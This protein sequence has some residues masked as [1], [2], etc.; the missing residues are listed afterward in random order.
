MKYL[1]VIFICLT[2]ISCNQEKNQNTLSIDVSKEIIIPKHYIVAKTNDTIIIDGVA[3]ET[4]WNT[5]KFSDNFI[6]I[7]GVKT[8][9]FNTKVKMLWDEN[10]LY[11]YTELN[12]PHIWGHLKQRD[13]IIY[14]NNDFEVFLDPSGT[15][16]GYGEIEIN[17]LNTVWDLYLNKPYRIGGKANFEWNLNDLKSAVKV[18]GTLN[19]PN[20]IDSLWTVEMAIPLKPLIGLKNNPKRTPK[21]GEQWRINFSRVEWEYDIIAG[22][23][24]RRKEGEKFLS[25][26]NWVWSNQKVI[27]MHEPE[28]WGF[29]QFTEKTSSSNIDFIKDRDVEIKQTAFALFR[30]TRYGNLKKLLEHDVGFIQNFEITYSEGKIANAMFYKTNF[31]FE[32]K[33]KSSNTTYII[34]QEGT[35]KTL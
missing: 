1:G 26:H 6:D 29:L 21:E 17:A 30:K 23:Y 16:I 10:F 13:T 22:T 7:E 25:E 15:G 8:P 32:F 2:I 14:Y 33:L 3:N 5:T 35:L 27:N 19:N 12:E 4:S 31:G 34:N 11:V 24:Y 20:D 18:H 9:K 28:K